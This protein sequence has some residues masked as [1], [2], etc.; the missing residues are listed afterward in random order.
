MKNL[1]VALDDATHQKSRLRAAQEGISMSRYIASLVEQDV[2]ANGSETDD[3]RQRRLQLLE[4]F[5]SGPKYKI[6]KNGRMP[7][8]EERNARR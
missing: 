3:T 8:A 4:V 7:S 1:T 5:L 6:S 2:L